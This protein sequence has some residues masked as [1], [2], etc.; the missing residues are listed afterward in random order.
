MAFCAPATPR[1]VATTQVGPF[2]LCAEVPRV[3]ERL[4]PYIRRTPLVYSAALSAE[5]GTRV[6]LKV[7]SEQ[8]SGTC[9]ARSAL[10]HILHLDEET[11]ARGVVAASTGN[12]GLGLAWA[13]SRT[14]HRGTVFL[15]EVAAN[16]KARRLQAEGMEVVRY[17]SD[18]IEAEAR[19]RAYAAEQGRAYIPAYNNPWS[20]L[21]QATMAEE[22]RQQLAEQTG[23]RADAVL[24]AVGGGGL[25][26][27]V[28]GYLKGIGDPV[29]VVGCSPRH[30]AVLHASIQAGHIVDEP[31][32][33]TL[34]DA[35][36]GGVEPG[37]ITFDLVRSLSDGFILVEEEEI[38]RALL[39]LER[40]HGIRVE[41]AA[42]VVLAALRREPERFADRDVVLLLC[43]GNIGADML[44]RA[45][46]L[47][48]V[49]A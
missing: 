40:L 37:S 20:I 23:R 28:A 2:D 19:A 41:G 5:C 8:H 4:R 11:L 13:L 38:A 42:A 44:D 17:G 1:S 10:N 12:H 46:S 7:E 33:P 30:S 31:S 22:V 48:D 9:K 34:S 35:T 43:G 25:I 21:G 29:T 26:S 47:L 16:H 15:P 45:R 49:A 32:L 36:A 24:V 14:R 3:C 18:L 27:G 39:D 6:W